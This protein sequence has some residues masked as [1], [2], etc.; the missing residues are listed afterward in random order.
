MS[1]WQI[2]A[3]DGGR[4]YSE[5]CIKHDV[6]M[7]G[8]GDPGDFRDKRSDYSRLT[9]QRRGAINSLCYEMQTNDVVLLRRGYRIVAI[10]VVPE[11]Q[12]AWDG[13]FDDVYGWDLQHIQRV[14]WQENLAHDLAAIQKSQELFN[15]RKQIVTFPRVHDAGILKHISAIAGRCLVRELRDLP[16]EPGK[17]LSEEDVGEGLFSY[18]LSQKSVEAVLSA[19]HR[20]RRL[21]NWYRQHGEASSRPT[22]HEV[23]AHMVLPM[24]LA[25]GWSEQLLAVEW[26]K[27]DLAAF[28][29]TPTTAEECVMLCE[30][31]GMWDGLQG[32]LQQAQDYV[33]KLILKSCRRILLTQG[34]RFYV[35]TREG[36]GKWSQV[37]SGY[38]N[39]DRLRSQYVIPAKTA[40]IATIMSLTPQ[41][42]FGVSS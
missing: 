16:A 27:V 26:K 29:T 9:G 15:G 32:T 40:A 38:F 31:K 37:P 17:E 18:G 21:L 30:A 28:R 1:V 13:R 14:C 39:V 5:L 8:P 10:G 36:A 22:E 19:F 4:D 2:A 11:N 25:L 24:L 35:Y 20:Q 6:M 12:Y 33:T 42:V 3:G 23:V 34:G 7:M 41:S